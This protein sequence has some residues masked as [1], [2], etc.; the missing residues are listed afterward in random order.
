MEFE[1]IFNG[2]VKYI[3]KEIFPG[4]NDLQVVSARIVMKRAI[5]KRAALKE[6]IC[7]SGFL[8]TFAVVDESG[9]VDIDGLAED[10]KGQLR[11]LEKM[12]VRIPMFGTFTFVENDVDVLVRYIK[13]G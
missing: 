8:R 1:K 10:L 4:F 11:E 12:Q 9:N 2:V 7:K 5:D 13:E 6:F 3:N